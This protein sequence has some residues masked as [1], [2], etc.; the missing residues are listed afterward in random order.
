MG[1]GMG[2]CVQCGQ[3]AGFGKDLCGSCKSKHEAE[4]RRRA[5]EAAAAR[6]KAQEEA[7]LKAA[8]E[9]ESRT[10]TFV[11]DSMRLIGKALSEGLTPALY[12][13]ETLSTTYAL[14]GTMAGSPPDVTRLS[15]LSAGGWRVVAT[16]PQTEGTGLSNRMG[17]GAS[18]WG[19]GVGGLVT[20]VYVLL[21]LPL[22]KDYVNAN[23]SYLRA[24]IRLRY[25]D[26]VS[27]P[28][29]GAAFEVPTL[30]Q[31]PSTMSTLATVGLGAAGGL[32]VADAVLDMTGGDGVAF[33]GDGGGGSDFGGFDF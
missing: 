27:A 28:L 23:E 14:N 31:G 22:T 13:V 17:N 8:R 32:L 29:L 5:E 9:L 24:L 26:G 21:E 7:A 18:V 3:K 19:G 1:D 20:G 6:R 16:V 15:V 4:E 12:T 30:Q 2:A 11:D 33:E 10:S 25:V